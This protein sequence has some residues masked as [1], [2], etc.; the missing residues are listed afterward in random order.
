MKMECNIEI[1]RNYSQAEMVGMADFFAD[2]YETGHDASGP[3]SRFEWTF[4]PSWNLEST[5]DGMAPSER[6]SWMESE[7]A[8]WSDDGDPERFS[9]LLT[10]Q[11][12]TPVIA[13][14]V[15]GKDY[16]WDGNH[17][18]AASLMTGRATAPAIVGRLTVGR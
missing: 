12:E 9:D 11:I 4:E 17:R 7:I 8:I 15:N 14:T 5:I 2:Q 10:E 3:A 6:I 18:V 16:L 13:V 1:D